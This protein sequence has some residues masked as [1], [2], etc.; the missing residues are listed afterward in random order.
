MNLLRYNITKIFLNKSNLKYN[1]SI[2]TNSYMKNNMINKCKLFCNE[3]FC[4]E[5]KLLKNIKYMSPIKKY[6]TI[7]CCICISPIYL[8]SIIVPL[9]FVICIPPFIW[10]IVYNKKIIYM[11]DND[12]NAIM[13][14]TMI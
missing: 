13:I 4:N 6:F 10:W 14:N 1:H 3:L 12:Y 9:G 8:I 2:N 5:I 11:T 7:F